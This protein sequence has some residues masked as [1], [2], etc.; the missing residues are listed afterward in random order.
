MCIG[1]II[2]KHI[3]NIRVAWIFLIRLVSLLL[4]QTFIV[5]WSGLRDD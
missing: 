4:S 2:K 5:P 3:L 1:V